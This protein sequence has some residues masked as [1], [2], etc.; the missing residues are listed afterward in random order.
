MTIELT[1]S[2]ASDA[3]KLDAEKISDKIKRRKYIDLLESVVNP[4]FYQ[5]Y[6][7]RKYTKLWKRIL[8]MSAEQFPLNTLVYQLTVEEL[9]KNVDPATAI[10][11][12]ELSYEYSVKE[13]ILDTLKDDKHKAH[14]ELI[15]NSQ[16]TII[17]AYQNTHNDSL[18]DSEGNPYELFQFCTLTDA[19]I[20]YLVDEFT[21]WCW[22][23]DDYGYAHSIL[24]CLE[25]AKQWEVLE[26]LENHDWKIQY[27][28][29]MNIPHFDEMKDWDKGTVE[30]LLAIIGEYLHPHRV[31]KDLEKLAKWNRLV[32]R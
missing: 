5:E 16:E 6:G 27:F 28:I 7:E 14:R 18:E 12:G 8:G 11:C 2:P 29:Y 32:V 22:H 15:N 13:F 21:Q 25:D 31:G 24:Q 1:G 30:H 9:Y 23:D 19:T 20:E 17:L 26:R 3:I 4:D 10:D